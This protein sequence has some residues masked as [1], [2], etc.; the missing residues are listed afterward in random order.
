M[1]RTGLNRMLL[2]VIVV[3]A[4]L[5]SFLR[6]D[7]SQPNF[8]FMP[9]MVY[10]IPYDSFSPN[11]NFRD[12]KT[13]QLP[14][15]GTVA[16]GEGLFEYQATEAD[17]LR[18]GQEL[19]SPWSDPKV[20][21]IALQAA[22]SRGRKIF[23]TFCLPCHGAVGNGDGP[24]AMH[25]FPP[26]PSLSLEKSL[27]M[28]DGQMFH[29]L[30]F[31]Q[32][33]MPAYAA[34]VSAPDRWKAILHVR[35]L[36]QEAVLKAEADQ[37]AE[38]SI[39]VGKVVF[40][41]LNCH[42]CHAVLPE[43]TVTP[44]GEKLAA[45]DLRKVSFV[46]SRAQLLEAISLPSKTIA[47][48]FVGELF[49]TDEGVVHSGIVIRETEDEITL[50]NAQGAD[51]VLEAEAIE[52]R[53]NLDKSAMPD[54]QLKDLPDDELQSLLDYLKSIAV[55]PD[56]PLPAGLTPADPSPADPSQPSTG[57]AVEGNPER[58]QPK[59]SSGGESDSR[60]NSQD[61]SEHNLS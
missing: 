33:N 47:A 41:R 44:L 1:S 26:P 11:P 43:G 34:Q 3:L 21:A 30:T 54:G 16:R 20:D 29:V 57:K 45:P 14:V 52:I 31:G 5:A 61:N 4:L 13:L 35:S 7:F 24:V 49:L 46:Y 27:K 56:V 60:D 37:L 18:A 25:G 58:E 10:S 36:Q 40:E 55:E 32:K 19:T 12:G 53:K 8:V 51:V 38:A 28:S 23:S 59:P 15:A 6:R 9:E 22:K 42:K 2:V 39:A 50:R 48:G 17:A